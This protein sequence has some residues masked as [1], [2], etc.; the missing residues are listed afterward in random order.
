MTLRPMTREEYDIEMPRI[1]GEYAKDNIKSGRWAEAEAQEKSAADTRRL[2]P[3]GMNSENHHFFIMDQDGTDV[4]FLW[5]WIDTERS[6]AQIFIYDI[7]VRKEHRRKGY[8]EA[9]LALLE[10]WARQRG[11][12]KIG[13]HVFAFNSGAIA[14]YEKAGYK[15]TDLVMVRQLD[16]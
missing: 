3:D 13:L 11:L 16:R 14:L 7:E 5:V 8:G 4:G 6:E 1:I 2:L 10:D 9:S 12:M 15:T